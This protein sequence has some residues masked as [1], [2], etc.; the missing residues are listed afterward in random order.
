MNQSIVYFMEKNIHGAWVV[1]GADGVKQYYGYTKA[2]AKAKYI[3]DSR[4]IIAN[5]L[6]GDLNEE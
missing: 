3:A 5:S 1:Y 2:E 6:V 4:I